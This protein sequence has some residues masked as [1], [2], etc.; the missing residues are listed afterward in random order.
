M[1]DVPEWAEWLIKELIE[2][3]ELL[4]APA[5]RQEAYQIEHRVPVDELPMLLQDLTYAITDHRSGSM[6]G[7]LERSGRLR[8]DQVDAIAALWSQF[9]AMLPDN[10]VWEDEAIFSRPEWVEV[11]RLAAEALRLLGDART[12]S[13]EQAPKRD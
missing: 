3:L 5:E 13:G 4:A 12:G 1:E 7:Q 10:S 8:T 9:E 6:P 2:T 11:R